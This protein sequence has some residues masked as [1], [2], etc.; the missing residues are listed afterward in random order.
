[1]KELSKALEIKRTLFIVYYPQ[2]DG[3]M[4]RIN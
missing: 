3:Q 1:M 4:E 2:T